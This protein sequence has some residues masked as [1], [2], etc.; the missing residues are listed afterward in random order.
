MMSRRFLLAAAF[1]L[2]ATLPLA[3][4]GPTPQK[5][6]ETI[7]IAAT[8]DKV[9]ALISR[10]GGIGD[11]HPMVKKVE[12]TGD[13]AA[14]AERTLTLE[15]GT[16]TEGLDESDAAARRISWR[17]LEENVEAVPVSFYTATIEVT[18][19]GE[20]SRVSWSAR[21]YRGDTSNF[22]PDELNDEA[23]IAA[24]GAYVTKGLEGLKA[25]AE[26]P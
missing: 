26:A 24:M 7:D 10:F 18:P 19:A 17:L 1:L 23:A 5:A 4:H 14:G 3:A 9:W 25:K 22:P 6:D 20:G 11:W 12:A 13:D 16:L 21:F 8:P 15:G 2:G